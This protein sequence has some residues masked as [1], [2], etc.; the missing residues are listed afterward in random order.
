MI[1]IIVLLPGSLCQCYLSSY[2]GY[3]VTIDLLVTIVQSDILEGKLKIVIDVIHYFV[4]RG[5]LLVELVQLAIAD[6]MIVVGYISPLT[7]QE[8]IVVRSQEASHAHPVVI[9]L[10][11]KLALGI[12]VEPIAQQIDAA[13]S[14]HTPD[15]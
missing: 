3:P 1:L 6:E 10:V 4:T 13:E 7:C 15:G 11:G 8:S 14:L 5:S 12:G 9:R 2:T